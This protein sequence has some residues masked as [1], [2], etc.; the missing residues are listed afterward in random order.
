[1]SVV[2]LG[3]VIGLLGAVPQAEAAGSSGGK[4]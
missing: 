4:R 1:M 2:D 3:K